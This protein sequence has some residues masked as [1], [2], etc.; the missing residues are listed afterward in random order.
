M[1]VLVKEHSTR[2]IPM[3]RGV[4]QGDIISPKLFTTALEDVFKLLEWKG[5][6]ININGEYIT[7]LRFA[8]DIVLMAKSLEDLGIMLSD[9]DGVFLGFKMNMDKTK[10]ILNVHIVPTPIWVG[11]S[12]LEVVDEYIYLGQSFQLGRSNIEKKVNRRI[13]LGW[14]AF[15]KLKNVFSPVIPQ[16]LKS[17]V[18]DQCVLLVM[19]YGTETWSLT[20]SLLNKP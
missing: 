3:Q 10:I 20:M 12:T 9:L 5:F 2:A 17:K 18:F 13:K 7:H 6:G 11:D 4:R 19:T 15:G 16:C 1:L 14:A 8:D